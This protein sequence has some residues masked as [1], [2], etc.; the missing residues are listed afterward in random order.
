M[1]SMCVYLF[2]CKNVISEFRNEDAIW[3][4]K[5]MEWWPDFKIYKWGRQALTKWYLP[6]RDT[7]N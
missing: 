5:E 6:K 4:F 2:V 3:K 1:Y 7:G